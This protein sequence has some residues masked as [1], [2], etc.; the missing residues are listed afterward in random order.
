MENKTISKCICGEGFDFEGG[1]IKEEYG[2]GNAYMFC[3][4]G[5]FRIK[6]TICNK[7]GRKVV[8]SKEKFIT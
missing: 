2:P 4:E 1:N 5:N 6:Y 8:L 7:C 3:R